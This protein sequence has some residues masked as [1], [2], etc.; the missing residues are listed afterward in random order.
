MEICSGKDNR[1]PPALDARAED[2]ASQR[3]GL[4]LDARTGL[5]GGR[6]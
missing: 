1:T 6:E 4:G 3:L 2:T 5:C